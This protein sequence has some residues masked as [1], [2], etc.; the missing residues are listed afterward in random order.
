MTQ[1][2]EHEQ[3]IQ[4]RVRKERVVKAKCFTNARSRLL[5]EIGSSCRPGFVMKSEQSSVFAAQLQR[6]EVLKFDKHPNDLKNVMDFARQESTGIA[7]MGRFIPLMFDES[8]AI[9]L[10]LI[11][12]GGNRLAGSGIM[13][14]HPLMV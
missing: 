7:I 10:L 13:L 9:V 1:R 2:V 4:E 5:T 14:V 6:Y 8:I 3:R 12:P 11:Y